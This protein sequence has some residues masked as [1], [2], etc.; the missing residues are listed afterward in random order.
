MPRG[1]SIFEHTGRQRQR[2]R[3]RH[4]SICFTVHWN[5]FRCR[6]CAALTF[7]GSP[8]PVMIR[9]STYLSGQTADRTKSHRNQEKKR[10]THKAPS[11]TI[12]SRHAH[13]LRQHYNLRRKPMF[14]RDSQRKL[15]F[16]G[17]LRTSRLSLSLSKHSLSPA[18]DTERERVL[19]RSSSTTRTAS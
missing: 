5:L 17:T 16:F 18:A 6:S 11:K 3:Q 15:V 19:L 14:A 12:T 10:T 2:Q 13:K 4:M 1:L 8:L 9:Q 7:V